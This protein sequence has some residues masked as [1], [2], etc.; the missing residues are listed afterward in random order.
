MTDL[1]NR[2]KFSVRL[3]LCPGVVSIIANGIQTLQVVVDVFSRKIA[4]AAPFFFLKF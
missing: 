1:L 4:L 3:S 2:I